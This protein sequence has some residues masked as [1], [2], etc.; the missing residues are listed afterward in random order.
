MT[1]SAVIPCYNSAATIRDSLRSVWA[2]TVKADEVIVV[3][4]GSTD[5][6]AG[7]VEREFPQCHLIRQANAG[8]AAARNRGV[9]EARGD[10]IAFLD[11][12]DVWLPWRI[13]LQTTLA[14]RHPGTGMWCGTAVRWDGSDAA[15]TSHTTP[16]P[17]EILLDELTYHNPVATSTVLARRQL[18][19]DLKGF[20]TRFRG[21]EDYDLWLRVAAIAPINFTPAPLA[22]Y[23]SGRSGLSLDDE[24][25]L[26]QV[27]AVIERAFGPGGVLAGHRGRR[28]ALAYQHLSAC[29]SAGRRDARLRAW[30]LFARS[31]VLWPGPVKNPHTDSGWIRARLLFWLCRHMW[32]RFNGN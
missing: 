22:R 16:P 26:P 30:G 4:D 18:L 5:D 27:C 8:P 15:E 21:P 3:D 14:A 6:S 2:Q 28:R 20:D 24:R 17:R 1:I 11:S 7:I 23:R 12:D 25:F 10:W 31:V 9:A 29:W 19:Q 32:G 13:E